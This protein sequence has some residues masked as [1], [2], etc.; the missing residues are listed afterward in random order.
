MILTGSEIH[1]EVSRKRIIIDP[2]NEAHLNP[3]SYNYHL[4][5]HLKIGPQEIIDS[6]EATH[7]DEVEIPPDGF[8]LEPARVYLGHTLERI[9]SKSFVTS[10]IG[11]SS[12][13]RLGLFLQLFA[14]LG[15]IG[16]VHNWTLEMVVVQPLRVYSGMTIG[17]ISFWVPIGDKVLYGGDYAKTS[18]PLE[19]K[20]LVD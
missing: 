5:K 1:S 9:G 10:L 6:R 2:F 7:W 13:G 17:Q 15:Q 4:G 14:D 12:V 18:L 8:V 19:S 3:N 11:R 16:A 20:N